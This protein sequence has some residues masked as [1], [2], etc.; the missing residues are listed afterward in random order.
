MMFYFT[1]TRAIKNTYF[2]NRVSIMSTEAKYITLPEDSA[3]EF[4]NN[5]TLPLDTESKPQNK[6]VK[7]QEAAVKKETSTL[8]SLTETDPK[9]T[10]AHDINHKINDLENHTI[11]L[12][13]ALDSSQGKLSHALGDLKSR[14]ASLT[15]E[16]NRVAIQLEQ[17]D[18]AQSESTKALK[19]RLKTAMTQLDEQLGGVDSQ[20][21]IHH[22]S[23]C[24]LKEDL[25]SS[26][27][28]LERKLANLQKD[29]QTRLQKL[30]KGQAEQNKTQQIFTESLDG[31][32]IK[33][34]K[35]AN[36]VFDL[37]SD[38]SEQKR[39]TRTNFRI[40]AGAVV[41]CFLLV[42]TAITYLHYSET[43]I[44]QTVDEK[45]AEFNSMLS[46]T[47]TTK[48]EAT[49]ASENLQT[50]LGGLNQ[51]FALVSK[52]TETNQILIDESLKELANK[53]SALQLSIYG[54]KDSSNKQPSSKLAING[55]EW[56]KA[57]NPEHYSIQLVGVY[58]QSA[59]TQF[60]NN[61]VE[62]LKQFPTAFNISEYRGQDWYNLL[63]GDFVSFS[64]AQKALD[65]LPVSVQKNAPW[66]RG[67]ASVQKTAIN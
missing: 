67:M 32:Q 28:V 20:L 29:T 25:S 33:S 30:Y 45:L 1:H 61:H 5:T 21:K 64:D 49:L 16:I 50:E 38:L 42:A 11:E 51:Q 63:Y 13:K 40:I 58:R 18:E 48:T 27:E 4:Q 3:P 14:T 7:E 12:S 43:P 22:S 54:P 34:D 60:A 57:R 53:V 46:T 59:M 41:S 15:D 9:K 55:P 66:I 23:I 56:L 2:L 44:D 6:A 39:L 35:T 24:L 36:D 10:F 37:N 47:F 26:Y 65:A 31:L 8:V 17:Y 62:A 19:A 52:K